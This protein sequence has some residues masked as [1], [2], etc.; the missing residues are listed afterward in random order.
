MTTEVVLT[1]TGVP[2]RRRAGPGPGPLSAAV[3]SHSSSMPDAQR[4]CD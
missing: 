2:L 3:T 1:G 4:S